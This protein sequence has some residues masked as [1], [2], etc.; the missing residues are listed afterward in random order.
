MAVFLII[1]YTFQKIQDFIGHY[2]IAHRH[3]AYVVSDCNPA[4]KNTVKLSG[5]ALRL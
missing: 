2:F 4:L 5:V 1:F 3:S